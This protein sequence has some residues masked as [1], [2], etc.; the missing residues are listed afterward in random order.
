MANIFAILTAIVLAVSAFLAYQNKGRPEEAGRGYA[1]WIKK[2]KDE[3]DALA[4]QQTKL[5]GLQAV[6]NQTNTDLAAK[7][8]ENTK[9]DA[10]LK[11]QQETVSKLEAEVTAKESEASDKADE[12]KSKQDSL[13]AIGDIDQVLAELKQ[14]QSD[15]AQLDLDIA[16]A[17]T[18]QAAM[19]GQRLGVDKALGDVR[20]RIK[21]RSTGKSNPE[22]N[23][24][25]RSVYQNLGFVTLAG[26]DNLGIVKDSTLDVVRGSEVVAKLQV[27]TV[28]A[29]TAAA[30]IIPDSL[31]QGE[32][33]RAGDRVRTSAAAAPPAAPAP[34][35]ATLAP[36]NPEPAEDPPGDDPLAPEPEP[37][38]PMEEDNPFG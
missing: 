13:K 22:L 3:K 36:I 5:A 9:L 8:D 12:V 35:A 14:T 32:S 20:E 26:G 23:T 34:D 16:Q 17:E 4:R 31:A 37:E 6:L 15:I 1:G 19:E 33:V 30:D 10:D 25:V 27:T 29:N 28:E 21:W 38:A 11:A 7:N 24:A 18:Q 2:T